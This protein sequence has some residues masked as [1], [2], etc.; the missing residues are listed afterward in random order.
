MQASRQNR[1]SLPDV[2]N[3]DLGS[4]LILQR[5]TGPVPI[6]GERI[7]FP[8]RRFLPGFRGR[9]RILRRNRRRRRRNL[10][11]Y[12]QRRVLRCYDSR[13]AEQASGEKDQTSGGTHPERTARLG[14][15]HGNFERV[16]WDGDDAVRR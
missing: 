11:R 7:T 10:L 1:K 6:A 2:I 8:E 5:G 13:D 12:S 3:R 15:L 4:V 16:N 14:Y 9:R